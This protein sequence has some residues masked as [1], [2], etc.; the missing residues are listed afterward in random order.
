MGYFENIRNVQYDFTIRTD[1]VAVKKI[2]P[3]MTTRVSLFA[4]EFDIDELT[5]EYRIEDGDT[6]DNLSYRLYNTVDHY[7]TIMFVNQIENLSAE[8]PLNEEQ[9]QAYLEEKYP[10]VAADINVLFVKDG[11]TALDENG[12]SF[13]F[14]DEDEGEVTGDFIGLF[15]G[16]LF[17]NNNPDGFNFGKT[18][19]REGTRVS[20]VDPLTRRLYLDT[21]LNHVQGGPED[22]QGVFSIVYRQ[23]VPEYMGER[24]TRTNENVIVDK[25]F[26]IYFPLSADHSLTKY[27][28]FD[29]ETELNE[30]K[31]TIRVIK[32]SLVASFVDLYNR[33]FIR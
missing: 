15:V 14:L 5:D 8:W 4:D 31:R 1:A 13:I 25:N 27:S 28:T 30:K 18:S 16:D 2:L 26:N 11:Y 21:P 12:N 6:P 19:V 24:D 33:S 9:F 7:W 20:S 23:P 17:F 10:G 32:P 29:Y 22:D 3:D